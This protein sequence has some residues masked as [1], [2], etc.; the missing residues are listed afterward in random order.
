MGYDH[1]SR[2]AKLP[3]AH[4]P[5]MP[6]TFSPTP[7]VSDPDMNRGACVTHV[8]WCMLGSLASGFLWCRWRGTLSR[9]SRRLR[10]PQFYVSDRRLMH[11]H[12]SRF[13]ST[14]VEVKVWIT[15]KLWDIIVYP[16]HNLEEAVIL[17]EAPLQ[18]HTARDVNIH[19]WSHR[20]ELLKLNHVNVANTNLKNKYSNY[21]LLHFV[22]SNPVPIYFYVYQYSKCPGYCS[23][24]GSVNPLPFTI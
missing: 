8:S 17:R 21:V 13:K 24:G 2:Y 20:P 5:G 16:C 4:V 19:S 3:V 1:L 9:H 10:N 18:H 14:A 6:G 23:P 11:K 15:I 7:W 22:K 12:G